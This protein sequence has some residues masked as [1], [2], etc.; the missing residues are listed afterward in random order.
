MCLNLPGSGAEV[1]FGGRGNPAANPVGWPRLIGMPVIAWQIEDSA[2]RGE[3][4]VVAALPLDA[5]AG[6]V[7]Q[8]GGALLAGAVKG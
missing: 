5:W 3:A 2:A 8:A 4:A 1:E 7:G 6:D